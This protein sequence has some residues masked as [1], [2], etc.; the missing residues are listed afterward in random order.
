MGRHK[1]HFLVCADY[2][3]CPSVL[4][5]GSQAKNITQQHS[6]RFYVLC[7]MFYVLPTICMYATEFTFYILCFILCWKVVLVET[8]KVYI[9]TYEWRKSTTF[10]Q[11]LCFMF[12]LQ[13]TIWNDFDTNVQQV[14]C[15]TFK[16]HLVL[17]CEPTLQQVLYFMFYL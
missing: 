10:K 13:Y 4:R 1:Q 5:K 9:F 3:C 7:F 15:F 14:L 2:L 16:R 17:N 8:T 6:N 11:V 12:Y